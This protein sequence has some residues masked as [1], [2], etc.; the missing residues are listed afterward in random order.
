MFARLVTVLRAG[1]AGAIF[2]SAALTVDYKN[3]TDPAFCGVDSS[4]FKVRASDVGRAIAENVHAMFGGA[5]L[6][7]VAM[8]VFLALFAFT[9]FLRSMLEVRVMAAVSSLGALAAI[10]LIVAQV[11]IGHLCPLCMIVDV[12]AIVLGG[13]GIALLFASRRKRGEKESVRQAS[14]ADE[15]H[16]KSVRERLA[17]LLAGDVVIPWAIAG[18]ILTAAPF[19]WE[20]YPDNPPLPGPIQALQTPGKTTIVSFTDFQCPHCRALFPVLKEAESKPDTVVHRYMVPLGGHPGATPA[21][22]AYLC[23]AEDKREALAEELYKAKPEQLTPEG[24]VDLA[25]GTGPIDATAFRKCMTSIEVAA[26]IDGDKELFFDQLGGQGLPTTWV[27][28]VMIRGNQPER[29]RQALRGST[30]A[31]PVWAL[32]ALAAV[33]ILGAVAQS[34]RSGRKPPKRDRESAPPEAEAA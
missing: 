4:C 13:A 25:A 24:V 10:A 22:Q 14:D 34:L 32:Y 27:N 17:P 31:L 5:T 11:K 15:A 33:S 20:R 28:G 18:A 30:M 29:V 7:Q 3:I 16:D 1:C 23:I 9:F 12:S 26:K 6:P 19:V 2:G 8:V 21:A